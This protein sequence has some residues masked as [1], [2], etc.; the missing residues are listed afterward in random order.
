MNDD[1]NEGEKP[2]EI[3]PTLFAQVFGK[4]TTKLADG[5]AQSLPRTYLSFPVDHTVCEPGTF[6]RDFEITLRGLTSG[7]EMQA[8]KAAAG[9]PVVYAMILAQASLYA[10]NGTA[11]VRSQGH[12]EALWEWLGSKGRQL[13]LQMFAQLQD[14]GG[15]SVGKARS[16]ARVH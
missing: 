13:V 12:H 14:P 6:D 11:L 9:D 4:L 10:V 3:D 8:A 7:Q 1:E 15:D 5:R 16:N 2:A